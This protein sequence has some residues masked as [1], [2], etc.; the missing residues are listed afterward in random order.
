MCEGVGFG[1]IWFNELHSTVQQN[2]ENYSNIFLGKFSRKDVSE[3][4]AGL[5]RHQQ[6][7]NVLCALMRACM[8]VCVLGDMTSGTG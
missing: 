3:K 8:C 4:I 7:I 5:F 2:L 1:R 6:L